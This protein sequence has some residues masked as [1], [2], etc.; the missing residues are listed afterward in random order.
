MGLASAGEEEKLMPEGVGSAGEEQKLG[1]AMPV[2]DESQPVAV[3]DA[4]AQVAIGP[5]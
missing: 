2:V 3:V 5:F 1:M 4:D